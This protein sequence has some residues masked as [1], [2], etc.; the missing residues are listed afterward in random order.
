MEE[1]IKEAISKRTSFGNFSQILAYC[2]GL[3]SIV[4]IFTSFNKNNKENYLLISAI[5]LSTCATLG[6]IGTFTNETKKT[7]SLL[8]LLVESTN[9]ASP[10]PENKEYEYSDLLEDKE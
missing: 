3:I 10:L 4:F 7:T 2:I 1:L 6:S 9:S 5:G 8:K